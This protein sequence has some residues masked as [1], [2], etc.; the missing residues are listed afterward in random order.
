MK[1]ALILLL[2][3]GCASAPVAPVSAVAA[4]E[5]PAPTPEPQ[6]WPAPAGTPAPVDGLHLTPLRYTAL[7]QAEARAD[8]CLLPTSNNSKP[9]APCAPPLVKASSAFWIG[10]AVGAV[11]TVA[12][13]GALIY[14]AVE[15]V[16][17]SNPPK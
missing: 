11:V 2:A 17:A 4:L 7:L 13:T 1:Y 3:I 5:A 8:A 9:G 14:G 16:K 10:T 6:V 12:V 15:I